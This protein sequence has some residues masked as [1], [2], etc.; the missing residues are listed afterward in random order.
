[1]PESTAVILVGHGSRQPGADDTLVQLSAALANLSG[2]TVET[3]FLQFSQP[4]VPR[5]VARL[6]GT[7]VSKLILLPVFIYNGQHVTA[8]LPSLLDELRPRYQGISF[9]AGEPLGADHRLAEIL[10]ERLSPLL[11]GERSG[12]EIAETSFRIIEAD[13]E[14]PSDPLERAVAARVVHATGDRRLGRALLFSPAAIAS[15]IAAIREGAPIVTDVGMVKAGISSSC[16][17]HG[18]QVISGLDLA[19]DN[20]EAGRTRSAGGIEAALRMNPAAIVAVGNAPTALREVCLLIDAGEIK[21]SLVVGVPVG[22][23]GAVEAKAAMLESPAEHIVLPGTRG[24]S[25][26]AAAIVNALGKMAS[27]E[28][29]GG[30]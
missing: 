9:V 5:A 11:D 23:V 25:P 16:L 10:S 4:D 29:D 15:G 20:D 27:A 8:D 13:V 6:A 18:N 1:M 30:S 7:G 26:V 2:Q 3:A 17:I 21:P 19:G 28:S 22:F 12:P 14:L 24:G